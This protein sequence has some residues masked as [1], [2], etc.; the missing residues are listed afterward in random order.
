VLELRAQVD[1]PSSEAPA[2]PRAA[3]VPPGFGAGPLPWSTN[4]GF[5]APPSTFGNTAAAPT[6]PTAA[7]PPPLT[8]SVTEVAPLEPIESTPPPLA[9]A[10]APVAAFGS[11]DPEAF[12]L[13]TPPA[14]VTTDTLTATP[15]F[16][17]AVT[18]A[19]VAAPTPDAEPQ[20][21]ADLAAH[22]VDDPSHLLADD[23]VETLSTGIPVA[24]ASLVHAPDELDVPPKSHG[25]LLAIG[26][27]AIAVI[28]AVVVFVTLSGGEP[29]E[30][31]ATALAPVVAP[32]APAEA[33]NE[34]AQP[35]KRVESPAEKRTRGEARRPKPAK[36]PARTKTKKASGDDLF[37][38]AFR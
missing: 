21:S 7:T 24:A 22:N 14:A 31:P 10:A 32:A 4:G 29:T 25:R 37:D 36:A 38:A 33:T 18:E 13:P 35:D 28:A 5:G 12:A 2:T 19:P 8:Q 6:E 23:H 17:S 11:S 30:A 15:T 3:P 20:I 1:K 26:G 27:I 16:G 34:E 9:S